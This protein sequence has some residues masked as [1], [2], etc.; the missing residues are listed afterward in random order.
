MVAL[1]CLYYFL[2]LESIR[3]IH[4]YHVFTQASRLCKF[5]SLRYHH[6]DNLKVSFFRQFTYLHLR[7]EPSLNRILRG[8]LIS[9][10]IGKRQV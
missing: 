5:E 3:F 7:N 2:I 10:Y 9:L 1:V 6:K 4:T 8:I